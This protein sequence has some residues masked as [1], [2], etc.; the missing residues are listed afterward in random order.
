MEK[1]SVG[2]SGV[3]FSYTCPADHVLKGGDTLVYCDGNRWRGKV[4][5]ACV[6]VQGMCQRVD[7]SW[8]YLT[9]CAFIWN[10]FYC[11]LLLFGW[12]IMTNLLH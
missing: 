8:I 7:L 3:G 9:G 11:G 2:G 4:P 1:H 5:K 6:L 12:C 10:D